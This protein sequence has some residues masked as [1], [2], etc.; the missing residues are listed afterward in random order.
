M[1]NIYGIKYLYT[2]SVF[3]KTSQINSM[4][5]NK[6]DTYTVDFMCPVEFLTETQSVTCYSP[7][8]M[9]IFNIRCIVS[10]KCLLPSFKQIFF[11]CIFCVSYLNI[12]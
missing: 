1:S 8:Y 12:D 5:V 11:K 4:Q 6:T 2:T 3:R 9:P 10:D 7:T